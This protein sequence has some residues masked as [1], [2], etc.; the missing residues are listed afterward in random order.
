MQ[1]W[2]VT[3]VPY[4]GHMMTTE[5]TPSTDNGS[6]MQLKRKSWLRPEIFFYNRVKPNEACR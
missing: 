3:E 1:P 2:T 4:Q 6:K 5:Q